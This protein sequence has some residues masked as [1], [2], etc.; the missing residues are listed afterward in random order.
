MLAICGEQEMRIVVGGAPLNSIDFLLNL[1]TF[2]IVKLWVMALKLGK[3]LIFTWSIFALRRPRGKNILIKWS[4]QNG[5]VL[6]LLA[7]VK[8]GVEARLLMA[9]RRG[10]RVRATSN[11]EKE[12]KRG[13]ANLHS[14][15]DDHATTAISSSKV[16]A[17]RVE[18]NG[19]HN[20]YFSDLLKMWLT[21]NLAKLPVEVLFGRS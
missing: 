15:E 2:Q 17:S 9:K 3:E 5:A 14:L 10:L 19:G 8:N 7:E 1:Q 6:L 12:R 16:F 11:K 18:F 4:N 21:K 13:M 20:V